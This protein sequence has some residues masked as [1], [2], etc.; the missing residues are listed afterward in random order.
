LQTDE[1]IV[2]MNITIKEFKESEIAEKW[3]EF[4]LSQPLPS[5]S[6]GHNPCFPII[7]KNLFKY[8]IIYCLLYDG[9]KVIGAFQAIR[10]RNK[11]QS[12][13]VLPTSGLCLDS[14]YASD[15]IYKVIV[16]H[17]N[18]PYEIRDFVKFSAF[19][20]DKKVTCYLPLKE[21]AE[22]QMQFFKSKLRNQI[23]KGYANGLEVQIGGV[24]LLGKFYD[25][26]IR[27]MHRLGV[28]H[29]SMDYFKSFI[30][31]YENGQYKI[32]V[33]TYNSI[34][35]GSSIV[36]TYGK[37]A[38]L[39]WA[40]TTRKYNHLSSNMVLYWEVIKFS[41]EQGL[42]ILS[43]GRSNVESTSLR[44]KE[45]W[46]VNV[47]PIYFNYSSQQSNL[48]DYGLINK[49]WK[50]IPFPLVKILGPIIR[51]KVTS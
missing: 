1:I 20:F 24:E 46:G 9:Q 37:L 5:Y 11:I 44:F 51:S 25:I 39:F 50:N 7:F 6:L 45:Q 22:E 47:Y 16:D 33:V 34:P 26:Y 32:F 18:C 30:E 14:N 12:L 35:I 31:K 8:E 29:P 21:N 48:R 3:N 23:K 4:V 27:N 2:I 15:Y 43:F 13:P 40:S 19:S 10:E 36:F 28:P 38:E 42:K 41:I 49:I 17:F